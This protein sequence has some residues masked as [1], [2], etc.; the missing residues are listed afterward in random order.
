[1]AGLD[2]RN[3]KNGAPPHYR[4]LY[5]ELRAATAYEPRTRAASAPGRQLP[6]RRRGRGASPGAGRGHRPPNPAAQGPS[7][8]P[9][10]TP[11]PS[12]LPPG[13]REQVGGEWW[14][15][16]RTAGLAV[17]PAAL[18]FIAFIV[19]SPYLILRWSS[20]FAVLITYNLI[21]IYIS[22]ADIDRP[23]RISRFL[24]LVFLKR[25]NNARPKIYPRPAFTR[26]PPFD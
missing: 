20:L 8:T 15:V 19:Y 24:A 7:W 5:L 1:V 14:P 23:G 9:R 13:P 3:A 4:I 6:V 25:A 21:Y 18:L 17:H 2:I 22:A 12:Q 16:F 26:A 10:S 11:S